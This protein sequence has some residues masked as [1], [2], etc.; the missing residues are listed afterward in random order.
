MLPISRLFA[1]ALLVGTVLLGVGAA[2][3][4][5]LMGDASAQLRLIAET[6]YF[7][8]LHLVMLAGS[9]LLILGFWTRALD[10]GGS[11]PVPLFAA[12]GLISLR[13][14]RTLKAS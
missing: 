1:I 11:V 4:P 9:G 7:R 3:H 5:M 2:M 6:A 10:R 14:Y 8:P 12:L 13:R